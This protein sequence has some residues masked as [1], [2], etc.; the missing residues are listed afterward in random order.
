[1]FSKVSRFSLILSIIFTLIWVSSCRKNEKVDSNPAFKL[2]FSTDT[3]FFDTVFTTVG[4][5]TQRLIVHN[6]N[7]NKVLVSSIKLAGNNSVF[8]LNIDGTPAPSAS[9]VEIPGHD[10]IFIF[11]KVTLNPNNQDNPLVITDSILFETNGNQQKV[12]LVAWG[13]DAFF[14]KN[15]NLEG[16]NT[17]DSIKPH[18]I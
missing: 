1:M 10:S 8:S 6:D 2:S 3:V 11:V 9:I 7:S 14:Y 5:V 16:T 13:Q 17:W 4:S 15:K 12:E 18:V